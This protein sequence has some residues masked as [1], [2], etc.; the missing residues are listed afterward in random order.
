[1]N[2]YVLSKQKPDRNELGTEDGTTDG[3]EDGTILGTNDGIPDGII[4]GLNDG[5]EF[6]VSDGIALGDVLIN[7]ILDGDILGVS[8][9]HVPHE[10]LQ[11]REKDSFLQLLLF[12]SSVHVLYFPFNQNLAVESLQGS[13]Q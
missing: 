4:L 8:D 13:S 2:L 7:R 10:T 11:V 12:L 5:I 3:V 1:M 6:G 9:G